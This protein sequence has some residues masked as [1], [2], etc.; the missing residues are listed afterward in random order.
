MTHYIQQ[1]V[2]ATIGFD[3]PLELSALEEV[4]LRGCKGF[5]DRER[6]A[7]NSC[8]ATSRSDED[9]RELTLSCGSVVCSQ[10]DVGKEHPVL[11]TL[12]GLVGR[13]EFQTRFTLD[14]LK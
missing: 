10:S 2:E 11:S 5:C 6:G 4:A 7:Q 12:G 14:R 13:T 3:E 8:E 1:N 9:L